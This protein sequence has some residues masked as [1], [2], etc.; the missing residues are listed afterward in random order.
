MLRLAAVLMFVQIAFGQRSASES[1]ATPAPWVIDAVALDA[2]GRPVTDLTADDFEVVHGG[3]TQKVTNFTWFDTRMHAAVSRPGTAAQLP[4]LDLVPDEIRRNLV[5]IVD[6][7]GLSPA[8]INRVRSE[9]KGFISGSMGPGD[10]VAVVR[11][12]SGE[13]V[14]QQL[15]GDTRILGKAIDGIRYLGGG[16]SGANAGRGFWL[17]LHYALEGLRYLPGRKV[18]VVFAE[19]PSVPGPWDRTPGEAAHAAHAAGAAV[20]AIQLLSATT[21][22]QGSATGAMEMLA[23]DSGG[24]FGAAFAGVLQNEQGYYAIGFQPEDTSID[25]AG[26]WSPAKA[27]QVKV[28]R[29]GVVVRARAGFVRHAPRVDF[30]APV[31]RGEQLKNALES[32]FS[33]FDIPARLTAVFTDYAAGVPIVEAVVHFD[34]REISVI[35]DLQDLYQGSLQLRT[36]AYTDDGRSTAPM[37]TGSNIAMR[38]AEY[39]YGIEHGLRISF[40]IKLPGPGAWQIRAV[41]ADG[42]SDRI[43]SAA[44]FVEVPNVKQGSLAMS[45][46]VLRGETPAGATV[47]A[48]PDAAPDVR[49]FKAG[50]RYTFSYAVFGA[51]S[52]MDKQSA[53]EVHTRIFAEG[54][55]VF[56]GEP[57]RV[58]FGETPANARRQISSQLNL[59]PLMA[60]GDYVLQVTVRDLLAPA[61]ES[62]T[63]TQ[64]T[65][66][67]LRE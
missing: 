37:M 31:D 43:G 22:T 3:R 13:G 48:D 41:V 35:H 14:L 16:T 12:S 64:F 49:I 1:T 4:A 21:R 47:S 23:R 42:T 15:T 34:A 17:A 39:R 46:L 44:Q 40:Q 38:P 63:A 25:P 27:A 19:N 60:S 62:R 7:L 10:R 9:L 5:V 2:T 20:Y 53:L 65:D 8:G 52:G 61:G 57:K 59:E 32:P 55:V 29:A 36:A 18:V 28:R 50:G 58:T 67:Q 11:S 51:L 56:D 54:R 6:D 30:P 26:R 45:G 33:G 66:F 24:L